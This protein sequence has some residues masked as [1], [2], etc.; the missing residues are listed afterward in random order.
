MMPT[1]ALLFLPAVDAAPLNLPVHSV[2]SGDAPA[3]QLESPPV[4][5]GI[6]TSYAIPSNSHGDI[7]AAGGFLGIE[8][9]D[10]N[11]LGFRVIYMQDPPENPLSQN[12]PTVPWAWGPVVDWIHNYQPNS[13]F[14]FYTSVSFGFV[15]G[16][17]KEETENNVILPIVEGGVGV[18]L[19]KVT[20][21]GGIV[22][23]APEMGL[24]PGVL[25]PY[26]GISVGLRSPGDQ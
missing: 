1:L 4:F 21:S 11:S 18:R 9:D 13:T 2:S 15:Y 10:T 19:S 22:Y 24:V 6:R 7:L 16:V 17:P 25:A 23:V 8:L 5:F 26:M 20:Q 3:I 12:S 14:S